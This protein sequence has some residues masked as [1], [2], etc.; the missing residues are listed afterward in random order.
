MLRDL[1]RC[2]AGDAFQLV[3]SATPDARGKLA[4]PL[5]ER[6]D[7]WHRQCPSHHIAWGLGDHGETSATFAAAV[8]FPIVRV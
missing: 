5:H 3:T 6:I 1:T 7:A 4:R 8:P 2:G